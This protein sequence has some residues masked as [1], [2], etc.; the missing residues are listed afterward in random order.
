MQGKHQGDN[1]EPDGDLL[2]QLPDVHRVLCHESAQAE[3]QPECNGE[4]NKQEYHRIKAGH[5]PKTEQEHNSK[6]R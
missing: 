5:A 2:D 6:N 3:D 1:P 4:T